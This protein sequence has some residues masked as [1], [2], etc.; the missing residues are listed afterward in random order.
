[1]LKLKKDYFTP[2]IIVIH[3]ECNDILTISGETDDQGLSFDGYNNKW[4]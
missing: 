1:M 4:L 3:L 2:R